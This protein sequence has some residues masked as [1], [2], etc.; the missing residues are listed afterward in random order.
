[1]SVDRRHFP[2]LRYRAALRYQVRG[3]PEYSNVLCE[4][5]SSGG[6]GI[7]NDR[8]IAPSTLLELELS[9]Y[10]RMLTSIGKVAWASA[11]PHSDRYNMGVQFIEIE[12]ADQR[13][14]DDY[15]SMQKEII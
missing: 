13:F 4:N 12:P 8:F 9:L 3:K 15:I 11:A 5:I 10:K 6:I 14:L 7:S 1:M 2:R